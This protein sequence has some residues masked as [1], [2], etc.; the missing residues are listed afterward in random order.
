LSQ[1]CEPVHTFS[2]REEPAN[3]ALTCTP[4]C[5]EGILLGIAE[6]TDSRTDPTTRIRMGPPFSVGVALLWLGVSAP[7]A[8]FLFLRLDPGVLFLGCNG[9]LW[10]SAPARTAWTRRA[11]VT[12]IRACACSLTS[13][14]WTIA[15]VSSWCE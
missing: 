10:S 1:I 4:R 13:R 5:M 2:G 3:I 14:N 11:W 7:R 15:S 6:L 8:L 12:T 9:A